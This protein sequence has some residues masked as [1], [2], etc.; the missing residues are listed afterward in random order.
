METTENTD[1]S[2]NDNSV[3]VS[4]KSDDLIALLSRAKTVGGEK[5][6]NEF[7]RALASQLEWLGTSNSSQNGPLRR[8]A[9]HDETT[10]YT[11][12]K[13][14]VHALFNDWNYL[15]VYSLDFEAFRN[16]QNK[17]LWITRILTS[18]QDTSSERTQAIMVNNG[19]YFFGRET[20]AP[21]I[22]RKRTYRIDLPINGPNVVEYITYITGTTSTTSSSTTTPA[23]SGTAT[24]DQ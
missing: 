8:F 12:T 23:T 6:A 13:A 10:R 1:N 7:A 3:E 20:D 19:A 16:N 5:F 18:A 11:D 4:A 17:P 21:V 2:G 24:H 14:V 22:L 9:E 15:L